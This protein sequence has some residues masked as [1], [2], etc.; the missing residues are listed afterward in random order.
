MPHISRKPSLAQSS[1]LTKVLRDYLEKNNLSVRK[2]ASRMNIGASHL[3]HIMVGEKSPD[4][5]VCNAIADFLQIPRVQVYSLAGWL[6][7]ED[8]DDASLTN[9]LS[10]ITE[11]PEQAEELRWIYY[12]I[13]DPKARHS[14]LSWLQKDKR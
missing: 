14:F 12:N 7:F 10:A 1:P 3:S 11:S 9:I 13:G 8:Q 2:A 4:A 6:E 5:G